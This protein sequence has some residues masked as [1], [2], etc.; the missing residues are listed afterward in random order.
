[1]PR[2]HGRAGGQPAGRWENPLGDARLQKG[3]SP[4]QLGRLRVKHTHP[5]HDIPLRALTRHQVKAFLLLG[6]GPH[7]AGEEVQL[8]GGPVYL[9]GVRTRSQRI[10]KGGLRITKRVPPTATPVGQPPSP[11][12]SSWDNQ[13]SR[14]LSHPFCRRTGLR[15]VPK[16]SLWSSLQSSAS[17]ARGRTALP[18]HP[19]PLWPCLEPQRPSPCS[20]QAHRPL[21]PTPIKHGAPHLVHP[22]PACTKF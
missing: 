22:V 8:D 2:C 12:G 15:D 14:T 3:S 19:G 1:M 21:P 20:S 16:L 10:G 5:S 11:D 7:L 6:V 18:N 13:A 17:T 9:Q 4:L